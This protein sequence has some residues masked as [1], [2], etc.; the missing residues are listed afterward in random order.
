MLPRYVSKW[1]SCC[2]ANLNKLA[3]EA[4]WLKQHDKFNHLPLILTLTLTLTQTSSA[5]A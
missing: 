1:G 5:F 4:T 2:D 3:V